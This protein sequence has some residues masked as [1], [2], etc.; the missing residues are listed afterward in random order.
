MDDEPASYHEAMNGPNS[1][2]WKAAWEKEIGRLEKARTWDLVDRFPPNT[3]VIPCDLV[4]KTKRD[5]DNEIVEHRLQIVAGG[6]KQRKGIDYEESFSCTAK[7]PS[8]RVVI[9]HATR[10]NWEIHQVDVKSAYLN[11]KLE[12][13]VYMHPP[14]AILEERTGGQGTCRLLKCLY[15]L[16]ASR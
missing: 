9:G 7:M 16:G 1:A 12:E 5:A 10:E 4:F 15:G 13:V 11:A 14:P 3:P 2:Q 6:H 8:C